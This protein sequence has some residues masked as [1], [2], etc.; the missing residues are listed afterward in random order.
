MPSGAAAKQAQARRSAP[1]IPVPS[2]NTT[3]SPSEPGAEGAAAA[4]TTMAE[5]PNTN[6]TS[7]QEAVVASMMQQMKIPGAA[8]TGK[9]DRKHRD[10][11]APDEDT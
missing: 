10:A 8:A 1:P 2:S 4:V 3:S 9:A 11:A 5:S 6:G 7:G